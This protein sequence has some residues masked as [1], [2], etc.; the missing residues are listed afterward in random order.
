MSS[1]LF[2]ALLSQMHFQSI[3]GIVIGTVVG[4][5]AGAVERIEVDV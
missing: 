2:G 1:A 5:V 3:I 4:I